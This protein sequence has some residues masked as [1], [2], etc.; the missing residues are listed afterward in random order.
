MPKYRVTAES[1]IGGRL[2]AP[3]TVIDFSGVPGSNLDPADPA[4]KKAKEAAGRRI[5][6][7][8]GAVMAQH[9][10]DTD[11]GSKAAS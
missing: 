2:V 8:D 4:A 10:A 7:T 9:M 1:F 11:G 6:V 3:G 5:D